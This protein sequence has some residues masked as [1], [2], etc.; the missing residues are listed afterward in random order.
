MRAS[1]SNAD[2]IQATSKVPIPIPNHGNN[3][4]ENQASSP[5]LTHNP[6]SSLHSSLQP[7]DPQTQTHTTYHNTISIPQPHRDSPAPPFWQENMSAGIGVIARNSAGYLVSGVDS[8]G[9]DYYPTAHSALEVEAIA[10]PTALSLAQSSNFTDVMFK[11]DSQILVNAINNLTQSSHWYLRPVVARIRRAE[12][13]FSSSSWRWI[14]RKANEAA[15]CVA[16]LSRWR[17][18]P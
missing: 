18:C 5:N 12:N 6:Q 4:I 9:V 16:S 7:T 10:A 13:F 14:P 2:F 1:Q 8:S 11:S 17:M 15:N 3:N